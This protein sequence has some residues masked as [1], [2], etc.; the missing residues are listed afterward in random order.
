VTINGITWYGI[1][2]L[3]P[4]QQ[5]QQSDASDQ[6]SSSFTFVGETSLPN[7]KMTPTATT[8][9]TRPPSVHRQRKPR[10]PKKPKSRK[11]STMEQKH[12]SETINTIVDS[13]VFLVTPSHKRKSPT[14]SEGSSS[15]FS[16]HG[17]IAADISREDKRTRISGAEPAEGGGGVETLSN[18]CLR[19]RQQQH[20]QRLQR[21]TE[22][23]AATVALLLH[24]TPEANT[25]T[26]ASASNVVIQRELQAA[27][28]LS[29]AS[30]SYEQPATVNPFVATANPIVAATAEEGEGEN[31]E[32][33]GDL[34][35][36][37]THCRASFRSHNSLYDHVSA[38]KPIFLY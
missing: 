36:E 26:T 21:R 27:D 1:S 28:V 10:N 38:V 8:A 11:K 29:G 2:P 30:S 33:E 20:H 12:S 15:F 7:G 16:I 14:P 9:A 24:R 31:E 37:W 5:Q 23:D 17:A 6:S 22:S 13:S 32:G 3:N 35:C 19:S 4:S 34:P 18:Y 25:T